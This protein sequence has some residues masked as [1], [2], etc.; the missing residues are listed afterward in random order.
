MDDVELV[1]LGSG[2]G[3]F[4]MITQKR[5]TG[6]IRILKPLNI[7]I[8]P[9]P[10]AIVYS[11][12]MRL[13]PMKVEVLM[14][15]HAHPDHYGDAE[16][17]IEAFTN[18]MTKKNGFLIAPQSV[19]SGV[20]GHESCISTYHKNMV[21][22]IYEVKYGE[23]INFDKIQIEICK[24]KHTDPDAVGFRLKFHKVDL[25][26]I[27]DTEYFRGIE[28]QYEDVRVLIISVLRPKGMTIRGH[29]C[30]DD[31]I[32]ILSKIRPELSIITSFGMKMI[33]ANPNREAE[34]IEEKSNVKTMAAYDGMCL[35]LGDQIKI[36]DENSSLEKFL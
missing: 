22:K 13:D 3:R 25:A 10:G 6:G 32:K 24:S 21:K 20:G 8:D 15:S 33:F 4:S 12:Q 1:F 11:N 28:D 19:I 36:F 35:R 5:H 31:A 34:Y 26:Y 9:G 29:L 18:G 16:I 2:G 27:S 17:F 7:Q 14:I 30:S 23:K